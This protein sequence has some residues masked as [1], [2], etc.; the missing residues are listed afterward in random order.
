MKNS[1]A[2]MQN[3]IANGFKTT[4]RSSEVGYA[5]PQDQQRPVSASTVAAQDLQVPLSLSGMSISGRL[6]DRPGWKTV[7]GFV[8]AVPAKSLLVCANSRKIFAGF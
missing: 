8:L 2:T 4:A 7:V 5:T 3:A 6:L 1:T